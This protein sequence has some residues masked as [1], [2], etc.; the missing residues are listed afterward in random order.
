MKTTLKKYYKRKRE[1]YAEHYSD[2][3][4]LQLK[5]IFQAQASGSRTMAHEM[6]RRYRKEILD[7]VALCTGEKKYIIND[8]LNDLVQ[9]SRHL[10][11]C[12]VPNETDTVMKIT[13]YVTSLTMNYLYTGGF[14]RD[15]K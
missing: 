11:L 12:A 10:G 14:R 5:H 6:I 4:D 13:A 3:H 8:I 15:K 9:R 1:F 2:F 7:Y